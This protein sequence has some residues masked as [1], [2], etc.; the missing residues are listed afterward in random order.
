MFRPSPAHACQPERNHLLADFEATG[1]R[2]H[3]IRTRGGRAGR[4]VAVARLVRQVEPDLVHTTLFEADVAGRVGARLARRSVV[5]SLVNESYG[6]EHHAPG[7]LGPIKLA[8]RGSESG[9]RRQ[10]LL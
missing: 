3:P 1:A 2:L 4:M 8:L 5:T 9:H 6:P 10:V 7:R